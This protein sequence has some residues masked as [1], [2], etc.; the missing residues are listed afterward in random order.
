MQSA[1]A[2][3]KPAWTTD[4]SGRADGDASTPD[5]NNGIITE[6]SLHITEPLIK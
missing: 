1:K 5:R 3:A 2:V 4:M 6:V